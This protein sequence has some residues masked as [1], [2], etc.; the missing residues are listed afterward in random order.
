[1]D[2]VTVEEN[3]YNTY[4]NMYLKQMLAIGSE[5]DILKKVVASLF[6]QDFDEKKDNVN[7]IIEQN[8]PDITTIEIK[9]KNSGTLLYPWKYSKEPDWWTAYNEVKHN[10]LD[11]AV[12]FDPSKNYYQYA[13]LKNILLALS[14]LHSLEFIAY[15]K[16]A[17]DEGK[18]LFVPTIKSLFLI[19]NSYW[20]DINYGSR[21]IVYNG[22]LYMV[23]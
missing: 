3:N 19:T 8:F 12:R 11:K 6:Q 14:A 4:S 15:R 10:R 1:F 20:K 2:Y 9:F 18:D 17:I 7:K 13:N 22:C 16:I 21:S 5:I 23:D